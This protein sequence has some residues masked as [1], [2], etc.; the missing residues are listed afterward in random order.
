MAANEVV[1]GVQWLQTLSSFKELKLSLENGLP[2][3]YSNTVACSLDK[4]NGNPMI[5]RLYPQI[6]AVY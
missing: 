5:V 1:H 4:N 6:L 3:T 2:G